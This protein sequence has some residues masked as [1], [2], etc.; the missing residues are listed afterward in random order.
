MSLTR[1]W[2][3]LTSWGPGGLFLFWSTRNSG[4][5]A[6]LKLT[7]AED[8]GCGGHVLVQLGFLLPHPNLLGTQ[9]LFLQPRSKNHLPLLFSWEVGIPDLSTTGEGAPG[10]V[11]V[12]VPSL[13][14]IESVPVDPV[15]FVD[16]LLSPLGGGMNL[17]S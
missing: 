5:G 9:G 4:N 11:F 15:T 16:A 13:L 17:C 1:K 8:V 6:R 14:L 12:S 2:C 7:P 10:T 3:P